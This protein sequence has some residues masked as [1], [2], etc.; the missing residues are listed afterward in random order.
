MIDRLEVFL[1]ILL[2]TISIGGLVYVLY[3]VSR[4]DNYDKD[5]KGKDNENKQS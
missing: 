5:E 1:I 2:L 3:R 4:L